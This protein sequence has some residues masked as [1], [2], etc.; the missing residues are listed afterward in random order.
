LIERRLP[1]AW[2]KEALAFHLEVG[3][4][5]PE[6]VFIGSVELCPVAGVDNEFPSVP[7]E[8]NKVVVFQPLEIDR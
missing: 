1:L 3:L 2:V 7:A 8:A 6:V 5:Q 4:Q